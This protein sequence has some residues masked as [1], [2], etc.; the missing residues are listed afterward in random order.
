MMDLSIIIVNWNSTD[1]ARACVSSIYAYTRDIEFE[2]VVTDNAS[3]AGDVDV[4]ADEFPG[5]RLIKSTRNLGFARANNLGVTQSTGRTLLFL[6]PDTKLTEPA[7]NVMLSALDSVPDAGALG[8]RLLNTDLSIQTSC[9]QTFPTILN[10]ALDAEVLRGLWPCSPLWGIA[11]LY[12][13]GA[14]PA[15][16]E[17]VSGACLMIRRAVFDEI[18]RFSDDFFMYAEDLDLCQKAVSAGYRNY[19]T[20]LARVIHFGGGSSVPNSATVM[21]WR[22]IQQYLVKHR[23]RAYTALFRL[24]MAAATAGRLLILAPD[25]LRPARRRASGYS[26]AAKWRAILSTLITGARV[27]QRC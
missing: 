22:A 19:H 25:S 11:P 24:V 27:H 6:N 4:L 18:G 21:K 20:G 15:P 9:I 10:Q 8:C 17:V 26:S 14:S 2:I 13:A 12:S 23:G 7:I 3:T 16:V 1:F 5:I